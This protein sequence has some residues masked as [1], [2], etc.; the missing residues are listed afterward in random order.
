MLESTSTK[1]CTKCGVEKTVSEFPL[2]KRSPGAVRAHCK[3]CKNEEA[4]E[5]R[6]RIKKYR[7]EDYKDINFRNN[8]KSKY[9]LTSEQWNEIFSNQNGCCVICGKHQSELDRKLGVE[10]NHKT[11]KIRGLACKSC[12]HLIDV[13]ETDFYGL[14]NTISAYLEKCDGEEK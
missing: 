11:K 12:N 13:F 2:D 8:I 10:H 3:D 5:Y 7:P 9:G 14:K 1:I 6:A 4:R